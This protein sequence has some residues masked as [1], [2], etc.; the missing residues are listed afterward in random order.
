MEIATQGGGGKMLNWIIELLYIFD[1][2][3][4]DLIKDNQHRKWMYCWNMAQSH[5]NGIKA[6]ETVLEA[7]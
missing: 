5:I 1:V 2:C 6:A 3:V 7:T 4:C